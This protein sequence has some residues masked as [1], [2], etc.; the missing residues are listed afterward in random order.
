MS[1]TQRTLQYLRNVGHVPG[2][3]ERFNSYGGKFGVRVDLFNFIDI[4]S[5]SG[6]N[7]WGVQSFGYSW[8]S[9]IKKLK[10]PEILFNAKTWIASGGRILYIGWRKVKKKR[11]GKQMIWKPRLAEIT[12][13]GDDIVQNNVYFCKYVKR[14]GESCSLNN[15]CKYPD[16]Q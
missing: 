10:E 6:S 4:I 1:P 5:L 16:C 3:V 12:I 15:K 9:H 14:E 2:M 7:I 8:S 11:G 13:N